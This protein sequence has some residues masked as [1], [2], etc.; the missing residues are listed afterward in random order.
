MSGQ[1]HNPRECWCGIDH[2]RCEK[3]GG[4]KPGE[5]LTCSLD[6]C[7]YADSM[8]YGQGLP[9]AGGWKLSMREETL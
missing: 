6:E 7:P 3:C 9:P 2:S 1:R 8:T 4:P 5:L